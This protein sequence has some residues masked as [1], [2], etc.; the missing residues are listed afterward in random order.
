MNS[1]TSVKNVLILAAN[2][3]GTPFERVSQELRDIKEGLQRAQNREQFILEQKLA[4]R[5]IDMRRAILDF[6]PHPH[7][8]HFCGR[9][10][11]KDGLVLEDNNGEP[12]LVSGAAL[13]GLF[14]LYT[15]KIQCVI[16]N[17]CYSQEQAEVI[18]EH[19]DYVIGMK[20]E[21][22]DQAAIAFSVGFYDALGAGE[23][24]ERAYAIGY[25][26]MQM[27]GAQE[28]EYSALVLLKKTDVIIKKP[29]KE[30][31]KKIR[32][33]I[34]WR[35]IINVLPKSSMP[36][37][38]VIIILRLLGAFEVSELW[39]YDQMMMSKRNEDPDD[40]ILII[41][42]T[43]E[44]RKKDKEQNPK[45][46][47]QP[48][49]S[50]SD[51]TILAILQKLI[52]DPKKKPKAIGLDIYR[53]F[54]T[55]NKALRDIL[56]DENNS[57]FGVCNIGDKSTKNDGVTPPPE[58]KHE[59][60]GFS[61]LWPDGKKNNSIV[62]RQM[63]YNDTQKDSPCVVTPK[64][65]KQ[66]KQPI[67]DSFPLILA[68][69]YFKDKKYEEPS[70]GE[71]YYKIDNTIIDLLSP[72]DRGGY[73]RFTHLDQGHQILLNYRNPCVDK[74][75]SPEN[76]AK[77]ISVKTVLQEDFM[78]QKDDLSKR[79]VLIGVTNASLPDSWSTPFPEPIYGVTL[80][81]QMLSQI[82]S[83]VEDE[84]HLLKVL[85]VI[86]ELGWIF[87]WSLLGGILA[88]SYQNRK[89]L[90]IYAAIASGSLLMFCYFVFI[91]LI[92]WI[93]F[94]PNLVGLLSTM[95]VVLSIKLKS[96]KYF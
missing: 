64:N 45:E 51:T 73:S 3:K 4:V 36:I 18:V 63:L 27:E 89:S 84:R 87:L 9:S 1:N 66:S 24:I 65:K 20:R 13:A 49:A 57:I 85:S 62:R 32:Q 12:K 91:S 75:C 92:I 50:L 95:A 2:P 23:P 11:G 61:D 17:S 37:T 94:V 26:A 79:I 7:I 33:R 93:P 58:F 77:T 6:K 39:L 48:G 25:N 16:L 88:Q 41:Q 47:W 40:R 21:I 42:I 76:V 44:D 60:L 80:Q 68:K 71:F 43:E 30:F 10:A 81:A 54:D 34:P 38:L 86:Q 56:I 69:H 19:I 74:N 70:D 53:D 96:K 59:R 90:I 31:I 46:L 5:P 52:E 72:G 67:K 35:G 28:R 14:K 15:D 8:V 22:S 55:K 83:A 82:L 78:Q 29:H